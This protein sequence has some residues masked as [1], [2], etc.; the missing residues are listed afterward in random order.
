MK[1]ID[2]VWNGEEERWQYVFERLLPCTRMVWGIQRRR[3]FTDTV[4]VSAVGRIDWRDAALCARASAYALRL[5][6]VIAAIARYLPMRPI[7]VYCSYRGPNWSRTVVHPDCPEVQPYEIAVLDATKPERVHIF[8]DTFYPDPYYLYEI[9]FEDMTI[10]D[11]R[12]GFQ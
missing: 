1:T 8:V 12:G 3:L 2:W 5:D 7:K 4:V 10:V 9:I 6:E 11:A